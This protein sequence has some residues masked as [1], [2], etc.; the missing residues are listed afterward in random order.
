MRQS[1]RE[2][3]RAVEPLAIEAAFEAERMHR[4]QQEDQHRIVDMEM[5]QAR[6]EASLAERRYAACDPDNRLIAAQLEKNW[7]TALRRVREL[8]T[9]QPAENPSDIEVDPSALHEPGRQYVGGLECSQCYDARPP[10]T[11]ADID[12]RHYR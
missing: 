5:Q 11:A 3:L 7:E 9:H 8:E 12:C 4:K 1:A 2:L 10:A 6:Y